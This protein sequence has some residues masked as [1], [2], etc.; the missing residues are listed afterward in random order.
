MNI[1]K[2][3]FVRPSCIDSWP[4]AR[5]FPPFFPPS[6]PPPSLPSLPPS[7]PPSP[8]PLTDI[9]RATWTEFAIL[10]MFSIMATN[11]ISFLPSSTQFCVATRI[12]FWFLP[13]L[14]NYNSYP[15][16]RLQFLTL[17]TFLIMQALL[18]I[19]PSFYALLLTHK[20][21]KSFISSPT[22]DTYFQFTECA[23][24]TPSVRGAWFNHATGQS[25]GDPDVLTRVD[26]WR[27]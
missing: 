20:S 1:A 15:S 27:N 13:Q 7:S 2:T 12:E 14:F 19:W 24:T 9:Q 4:W 10:A 16:I 25:M 8:A 22:F 6:P 11:I 3:I 5:I 23:S 18:T 17:L 21:T 26:C